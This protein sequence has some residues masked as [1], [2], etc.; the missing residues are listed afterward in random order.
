MTIATFGIKNSMPE[1]SVFP[2]PLTNGLPYALED[3]YFIR[4]YWSFAAIKCIKYLNTY[5]YCFKFP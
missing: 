5:Y 2:N 3:D 1:R 4:V